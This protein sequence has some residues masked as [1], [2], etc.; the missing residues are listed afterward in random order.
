MGVSVCLAVSCCLNIVAL[1]LVAVS[2]STDAWLTYDVDTSSLKD[3]RCDQR[4]QSATYLYVSR[5]RGLFRTC[6]DGTP[7]LGKFF[8]IKRIVDGNC[9]PEMGYDIGDYK[10]NDSEIAGYG[11]DNIKKRTNYQKAQWMLAALGVLILLVAASLCPC[12]CWRQTHCTILSTAIAALIG[13]ACYLTSVGLFFYIYNTIEKDINE[14]NVDKR[15]PE[16]FPE[17]WANDNSAEAKC[18]GDANG[19]N[20][21]VTN[22]KLGYSFMIGAAGGGLAFISCL[23]AFLTA[24]CMK[25]SRSEDYEEDVKK[26]PQTN[27]T[28]QT[29]PQ[30]TQPMAVPANQALIQPTTFVP[31]PMYATATLPAQAFHAQPAQA[32]QLHPSSYFTN[33]YN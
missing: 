28:S 21:D 10:F 30:K 8:S 18:L 16:W 4:Q 12:A 26:E 23:V 1:V 2:F 9:L 6:F 13:S 11:K 15:V 29:L 14:I 17:M 31:Q 32:V 20:K 27:G 22:I 3:S 33:V 7:N 24:L 5:K 19:Y 25:P